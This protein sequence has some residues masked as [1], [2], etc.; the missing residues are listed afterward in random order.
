MNDV[1]WCSET[2]NTVATDTDQLE[3][4]L[5]VN[6]IHLLHHYITDHV[7]ETSAM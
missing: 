5:A 2:T 4:E 1:E 6:V 3:W 7:V